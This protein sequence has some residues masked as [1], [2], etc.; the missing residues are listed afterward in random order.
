[1]QGKGLLLRGSCS[2]VN[3]YGEQVHVN[4]NFVMWFNTIILKQFISPFCF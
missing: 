4:E 3:S 1:M 2:I